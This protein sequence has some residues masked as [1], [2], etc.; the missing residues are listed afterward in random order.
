MSNVSVLHYNLKN[1]T[2]L[3]LELNLFF[4]VVKGVI[5]TRYYPL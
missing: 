3:R 5:A 2:P 1:D 4:I